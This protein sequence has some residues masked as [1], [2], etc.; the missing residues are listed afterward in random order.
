M[1]CSSGGL[2]TVWTSVKPG[3]LERVQALPMWLRWSNLEPRRVPN[4]D[5]Y[6]SAGHKFVPQLHLVL[7]GPPRQRA[8]FRTALW[9]KLEPHLTSFHISPVFGGSDCIELMLEK[10]AVGTARRFID[11]GLD[12]EGRFKGP[13]ASV[14]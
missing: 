14:V 11:A 4:A 2:A 6:T 8:V 7:T 12:D 5:Q 10:S 9:A 1:R 3:D 13:W